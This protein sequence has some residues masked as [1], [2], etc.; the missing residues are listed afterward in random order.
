[1][2]EIY[3]IS[4]YDCTFQAAEFL[5]TCQLPEF[6]SSCV[7]ASVTPIDGESLCDL[8]HARGINV[9]YLGDIVRSVRPLFCQI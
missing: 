3:Y 1:M 6:V 5:V 8:M 7:D 9:R 4:A 2:Y